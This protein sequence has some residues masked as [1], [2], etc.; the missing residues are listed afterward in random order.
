MQPMTPRTCYDGIMEF[1]FSI[2][3][4]IFDELIR[5]DN[6]RQQ[7]GLAKCKKRCV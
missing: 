7:Q 6:Y 2:I 4:N 5:D 1:S 3:I